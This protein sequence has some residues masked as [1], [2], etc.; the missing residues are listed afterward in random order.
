MKELFGIVA[1]ILTFV[2]YIP[3]IKSILRGKTK[4]H[5][6]S[7]FVWTINTS[8]VL[9]LQITNNAGAGAFMT[10][11]LLM[12]S[13]LVFLLA[14]RA[15]HK[16][17]ITRGD[18]IS[19]IIALTALVFWVLVQQPLLSLFLVVIVDLFAF[20]PTVRKAWIDPYSETPVFFVITTVRFGFSLAAITSYGMLSTFY[21][22]MWFVLNGAFASMLI[23]RRRG[24]LPR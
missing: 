16:T 1:V 22:A 7:W 23:L 4:P 6:Y 24:S 2:G 10:V 11:A 21:P 12:C 17:R 8:L 5:V 19:M 18:T 14:A 20:F 13:A 9:I 15:K 3:Y